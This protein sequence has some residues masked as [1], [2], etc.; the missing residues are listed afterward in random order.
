M[1]HDPFSPTDDAD[2]M[3]YSLAGKISRLGPRQ[4]EIAALIYSSAAVTPRYIQERLSERR[5][6]RVVRTL[7]DR[8]VAKGLVK[9]RQSGRHREIIYLAA[10][11]TPR[12]REAAVEKLVIEQFG[13]SLSEAAIEA[14]A[15]AKAVR[16]TPQTSTA[17]RKSAARAVSPLF[18]S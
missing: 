12:V 17:V 9:R 10:I 8:M 14:D 2:E 18:R 13:G 6:L 3:A 7:L 1:L 5:S 4:R 16:G 11:P 15:L